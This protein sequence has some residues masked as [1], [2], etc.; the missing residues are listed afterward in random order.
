LVPTLSRRYWMAEP[1]ACGLTFYILAFLTVATIVGITRYQWGNALLDS[2]YSAMSATGLIASYFVWELYGMRSLLRL[3]RM[4]LVMIVTCFLHA[5]LQL[6]V[7]QA[8]V[9]RD[10]E[11]AFLQDVHRKVPVSQLVA[12]H[13]W[14][15]YYYHDQLAK[16][17]D[18]LRSAG[19]SPYDQLAANPTFSTRTLDAQALIAYQIAWDGTTGIASGF[20]SYLQFNLEKPQFVSVLK[21]RFMLLDPANELPALRVRWY[22]QTQARL[23]QYNAP[24]NLT[25][26]KHNEVVVY[27]D[28]TI[29]NVSILPNNQPSTFQISNLQFMLPPDVR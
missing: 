17:L 15:T 25:A 20:N 5:N 10:A 16:Y 18:Q 7:Q 11:R 9:K 13:A 27:I 19:I 24:Y 1:T 28:D 4:F 3:G 2:R 12:H 6:G 29:S 22:S 8:V 23:Q 14:I 21:F 26:A